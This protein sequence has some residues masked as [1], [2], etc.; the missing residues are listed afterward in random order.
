MEQSAADFAD[1]QKTLP[2]INA[3]DA[4]H[5]LIRVHS[6]NSRLLFAKDFRAAEISTSAERQSLFPANLQISLGR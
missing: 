5:I 6:R 2:R 3:K 1:R 4:N